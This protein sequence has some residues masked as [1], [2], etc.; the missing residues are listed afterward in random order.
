M[1]MQFIVKPLSRR[2]PMI[3]LFSFLAIGVAAPAWAGPY[4]FVTMEKAPAASKHECTG[5]AAKILREL[6][7]EKRLSLDS[8]NDHLGFTDASTL[9]IDCI[10]VGKSKQGT[11]RW[12]FYIAVASTDEQESKKL[13]DRIRYKISLYT[14]YD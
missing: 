11:L 6:Q 12:I 3:F 2:V 10:S 7:E 13:I 5:R 9:N 8:S 4:L 1:V 14:P